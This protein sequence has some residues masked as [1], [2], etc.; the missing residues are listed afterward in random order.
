MR[1]KKLCV[2]LLSLLL[3]ASIYFSPTFAEEN[4][5][6][7]EG[8]AQ[9]AAI[10]FIKKTT[11]HNGRSKRE[12]QP[13]SLSKS[14]ASNEVS[15][16]Y[17]YNI[18]KGGF[19]IVSA[20]RRSPDI[21]GYSTKGTFEIKEKENISSFIKSYEDQ[22]AE[23]KNL[24]TTYSVTN[25]ESKQPIV[26]SLLNAKGIQY[27]QDAPYNLKTPVI[28]NGSYV[29][30]YAATGCV[31]TATAQIMKYHN[32]PDKGIKD[33]SY[34][35]S[36][37]Y[38]NPRTL[39]A[40]ISTRQYNWKDI[41]PSYSGSETD[42]QKNAIAEL[43]SDV[44]ISVNM[45]Y[46]PSSGTSGS[47]VVQKALKEN[48]GYSQSVHEIDRDSFTKDDWEVQINNELTQN[49]PVYYQGVG[50]VGGHAFVIDGSDG[51]GFYHVNWGW[52]G[53]SNGFFRLDALNPGSLGIGGGA[54]GFNTYQSAV[55]GIKP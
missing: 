37:D 40:P 51:N 16:M 13:I 55:V 17:I 31:A 36:N 32:Y 5:N 34:L 54:G 10:T 7:N 41:L 19:V 53:S 23:N 3:G 18:S 9:D 47:P 39:T 2:G 44:G 48:F 42:S 49:Q 8:E 28:E 4:F 21:L 25:V 1:N 30:E 46:G 12:A 52:G 15:N 14:P 45:N 38:F 27:N 26:N 43:M 11:S 50:K 6:R 33:H 35:L 22:I 20:D 29:G 24:D